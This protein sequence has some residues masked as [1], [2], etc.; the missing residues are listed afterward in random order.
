MDFYII[1]AG[2]KADLVFLGPKYHIRYSLSTVQPAA[3]EPALLV[4]LPLWF[5]GSKRSYGG[6]FNC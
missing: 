2:L 5:A 1:A 4:K 3:S 6:Q